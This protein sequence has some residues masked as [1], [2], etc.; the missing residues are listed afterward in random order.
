M[1]RLCY[2]K[3]NYEYRNSFNRFLFQCVS[4]YACYFSAVQSDKHF[5]AE[6]RF[7]CP[8]CHSNFTIRRSVLRHLKSGRLL[9]ILVDG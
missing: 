4:N 6:K 8:V 3:D 5:V 7:R 9:I 1:F 2:L